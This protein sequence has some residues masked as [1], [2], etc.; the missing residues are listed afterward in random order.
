MA[1]HA[2][3]GLLWLVTSVA[4]AWQENVR[5]IM[6]VQLGKNDAARFQGNASSID[7]FR[8]LQPDGQFVLI[9]ARNAMYNLTMPDLAENKKLEWFAEHD[10]VNLCK[11]KGRSE[12]KCQNYILVLSKMSSGKLLLCGTHAYKPLCRKY[13]YTEGKYVLN[14][15]MT[16]EG[17]IPYDPA[18][19][20]TSVLVDEQLYAGTVAGF[21]GTDP[22]IRRDPLRTV[23]YD[24]NQLNAPDFTSSFAHGDYVY[25]TFRETAVEYMNCGKT[26]Y[27]RIARVCKNDRGR[28]HKFDYQWTSFL[29]SRL[30]C[31]V[32]GDYPFYFNEIQST[33]GP[34]ESRHNG[35]RVDILYATFTT[36]ANAISGSAVCAFRLH[37]VEKVFD[38][39][40]K[41]QAANDYNW[42]PVAANKV[43]EPRPGQ[44]VNDSQTL[45]DVTWNFIKLHSLMD[46]SVPSMLNEPLIIRTGFHH[47]FTRIEVD[48][49]V[50]TPEGKYYDV[51]FI[52]TDNGK[53]IKAVRTENQPVVI[54]EI[55]VFS[56]SVPVTNLVIH[57]GPTSGADRQPEQARL[58]VSSK[59]EIVALKLQ[60]CYSDKVSSC[61]ECVKL[62]DPYCAWDK[63]KQKCVAVGSWT[64]GANLFQNV[65]SGIHDSCP[66][67]PFQGK[68]MVK[69]PSLRDNQQ[70]YA[71][72]SSGVAEASLFNA[73]V[74]S[75]GAA[76]AADSDSDAAHRANVPLDSPINIHSNKDD[77]PSISAKESQPKYT[78]ETLAIA[79]AAGSLAALFLGFVL[80]YCCG[81]K[82]RKN[83]EDNLPYPDTEYEYFEQRQNCHMRRLPEDP[84]LL[85]QEEATYAEP[86][87]VP[88][89]NKSMTLTPSN[90]VGG[91]GG[92]VCDVGPY[93]STSPK[94]TL[95]KVANHNAANVALFE[96]NPTPGPPCPP[97]N[98]VGAG[99]MYA[100]GGVPVTGGDAFGPSSRD[101]YS[102]FRSRDAYGGSMRSHASFAHG[103][104]PGPPP[105]VDNFGTL[106]SNKT[107][108]GDG[109]GTTRSVKKVYL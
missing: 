58:I 37:D 38:G 11:L 23:Q 3:L 42:L 30:N 81:R 82:C 75:L 98:N 56:V 88:T 40:F 16:G 6:Y 32:A 106:R 7:H 39:A 34:Y 70:G 28:P 87:L 66:D 107:N 27:S 71:P 65:A 73:D 101:P 77:G 85:S 20:S 47:R 45:P 95:R 96:S 8:Q 36:P 14:K 76:A 94:A 33:A 74:P 24:A 2:V 44:C 93:I 1:G 86:I 43:P 83:E 91:G 103:H 97:P 35:K 78:V 72:A 26:V 51:L 52:G 61:S 79:V 69:S 19:N 15:T 67:S 100:Y 29:K 53:V 31:S 63:R 92:G 49:Q 4:A 21:S 64:L 68:S 105:P 22:L 13:V 12:E 89:V 57:R 62:R 60:R 102:S 18:H 5:P 84:K 10:K 99:G 59:S 90:V 17:I 48:P 50:K 46:E 9:G 25:F 108:L 41:E 109:Y 104:G 54:E 55:Q 80:G